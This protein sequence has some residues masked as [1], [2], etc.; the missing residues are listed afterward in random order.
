MQQTKLF[1]LAKMT[2]LLLLDSML[3]VSHKHMDLKEELSAYKTRVANRKVKA[4]DM[5][6]FYFMNQ[7]IE[8]FKR[9][10]V[11]GKAVVMKGISDYG[12]NASN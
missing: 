8:S 3:S 1:F 10:E 6:A 2:S 4:V 5:E 9:K 7:A 12:S 11:P